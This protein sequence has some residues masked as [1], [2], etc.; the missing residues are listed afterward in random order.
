[1]YGCCQLEVTKTFKIDPLSDTESHS[2]NGNM[3]LKTGLKVGKN[4]P[5]FSGWKYENLF[6]TTT[7]IWFE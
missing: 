5:Q 2:D 6:E 4:I 1:M 7:Y 3:T